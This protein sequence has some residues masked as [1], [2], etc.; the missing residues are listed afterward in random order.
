M[1]RSPTLN[2]LT[3][4]PIATICP[5]V[6]W[7]KMRGAECD[8]VEIFFKSVPQMPQVYPDKHLT[9]ANLRHR[10]HFQADIILAAIHCGAHLAWNGRL[11]CGFGFSYSFHL[12][13]CQISIKNMDK[14]DAMDKVDR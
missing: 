3:P 9:G 4:S 14:V 12:D 11:G 2:L 8:P 10:D 6:S 7:P 1:T 13:H 5:A